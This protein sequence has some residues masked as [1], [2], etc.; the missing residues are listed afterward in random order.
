MSNFNWH[1]ARLYPHLTADMLRQFAETNT[2]FEEICTK[3]GINNKL[4][5]LF[6]IAIS[7][8]QADSAT[9]KDEVELWF[10]DEVSR[11]TEIDIEARKEARKNETA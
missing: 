1:D 10:A 5:E 8:P 11:L 3:E 9:I 6:E 4:K 2:T 7:D